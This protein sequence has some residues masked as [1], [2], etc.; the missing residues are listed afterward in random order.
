MVGRIVK[1]VLKLSLPAL[2]VASAIPVFGMGVD[3]NTTGIFTCGISTV[4]CTTSDGGTHVQIINNGNTL[5]ITAVGFT[6]TNVFPNDENLDVNGSPLDDANIITFDTTST[7]RPTPAG[8]V[9]TAGL[10]F[11]LMINQT[12]PNISPTSGQLL[13]AFSGSIDAR[14]SNTVVN[15]ASNQTSLT[16]GGGIVYTLDF[17][18]PGQNSWTI[19]NPGIGKTGVTTE[20]ATVTPEPSFLI[21]SGFGF[22]G[23]AFMAHRRRQKTSV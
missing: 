2:V 17:L 6:N 16:L 15:F 10:T 11:T 3:F 19:P 14:G 7:N 22:A 21:L 4:G 8:G 20:T 9:N 13:G 23:L 12:V 5:N 18:N 1:A